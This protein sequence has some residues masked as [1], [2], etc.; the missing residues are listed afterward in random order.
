LSPK[1]FIATSRIL[2]FPRAARGG[3]A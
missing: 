2:L 3:V 1:T